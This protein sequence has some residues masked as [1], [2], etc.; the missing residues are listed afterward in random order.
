MQREE[1]SGRLVVNIISKVFP[2]FSGLPR[3]Q[4]VGGLARLG[5]RPAGA[6]HD[7]RPAVLPQ[8]RPDLVRLHET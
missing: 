2:L 5:A 8:L 4:E 6:Q 1:R 7:A 3:L